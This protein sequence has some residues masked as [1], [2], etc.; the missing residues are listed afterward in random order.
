MRILLLRSC[1]RQSGDLILNLFFL[2]HVS[3]VKGS[4]T[5][6]SPRKLLCNANIGQTNIYFII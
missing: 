6:I 2:E 1:M 4:S 5:H 3:K